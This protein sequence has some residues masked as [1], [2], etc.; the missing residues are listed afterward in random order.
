MA[1]LKGRGYKDITFEIVKKV[2]DE[3]DKKRF[4]LKE[5]EGQ[6]FIRATQGHSMKEVETEELLTKI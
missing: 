1:Y 4:E 6:M 5:K 3:N 2:V